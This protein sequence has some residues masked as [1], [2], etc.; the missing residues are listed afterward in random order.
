MVFSQTFSMFLLK[1]RRV[2]LHSFWHWNVINDPLTWQIWQITDASSTSTIGNWHPII[3]GHR[4][5][6]WTALRPKEN[7]TKKL[8]LFAVAAKECLFRAEIQDPRLKENFTKT[9]NTWCS[10]KTWQETRG[11][12]SLGQ[13]VLS[14][15]RLCY[16][17]K[18][19]NNRCQ[20]FNWRSWPSVRQ[21]CGFTTDAFLFATICMIGNEGAAQS[22]S[23]WWHMLMAALGDTKGT[24]VMKGS[25]S[26]LLQ[27]GR[28][29]SVISF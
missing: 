2:P 27:C 8:T 6:G 16:R 7:P 5:E 23:G 4:R 17:G 22:V 13:L 1:S 15:R 24:Q 20:A 21:Q 12:L 26:F 19:K 29:H 10:D 9:N 28:W 14:S 3:E 18:G 11:K 25:H